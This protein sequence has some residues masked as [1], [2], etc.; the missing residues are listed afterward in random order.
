MSN[1]AGYSKEIEKYIKHYRYDEVIDQRSLLKD[2]TRKYNFFTDKDT[3]KNF[4]Q[5]IYSVFSGVP[6]CHHI[7]AKNLLFQGDDECWEFFDRTAYFLTYSQSDDFIDLVTPALNYALYMQREELLEIL[8]RKM[9]TYLANDNYKTDKEHIK[10]EVYPSSYLVHFLLSKY[11]NNDVQ[12]NQVKKYGKGAGIYQRIIDEWDT[13]FQEIEQSYWS[14][15][16]DYHLQ[17][18]KGTKRTDEEHLW[19][20]LIPMELINM[21][22][23]RKEAGLDIPIIEHDLFRTPMAVFPPGK[24]GY[25]PEL[26]AKFQLVHRTVENRK[27]YSYGEII[28]DL[29][30]ENGPD[31]VIFY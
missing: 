24:T 6:N 28:T 4:P 9:E 5:A 22:I 18:L 1:K 16:C 2:F 14:S 8:H 13:S 25:H 15:L 30:R 21:F 11:E 27:K 17:N 3:L 26:D 29:Q 20:G 23:V 19:Y 31:A 10:Q 7:A 12:Y